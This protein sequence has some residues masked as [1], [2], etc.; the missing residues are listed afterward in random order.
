[1]F[2]ITEKG[3]LRGVPFDLFFKVLRS[4]LGREVEYVNI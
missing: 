2:Y 3:D 1:M 4:Y